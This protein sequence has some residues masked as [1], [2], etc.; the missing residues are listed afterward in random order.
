MRLG[1]RLVRGVA[2]NV[3]AAAFTNGGNLLT[4]LILA[5]ILGKE[6]L[7]EFAI[8][9]STI[10]SI[11]G[12]A[13]VA[14][15]LTANKFVAQYRSEYKE[16]AGQVLGLCAIVT[17]LTGCI[18]T[19]TLLFGASTISRYFLATPSLAS[20]ISLAA[21]AVLFSTM[22]GFQVGA[23]AGLEHYRGIASAS[24]AHAIFYVPICALLALFGGL[25]GVLIALIASAGVRWLFF[26]FVLAKELKRQGIRP[27]VK[28]LRYALGLLFTF[29]APAA[30]AGVSALTAI[31]IGNA[32][33]VRQENGL[34]E[35]GIYTAANTLRVLLLLLPALMGNVGTSIINSF[36]EIRHVGRYRTTFWATLL[37]TCASLVVGAAALLLPGKMFL[38]LFGAEFVVAAVLLPA[39]LGGAVLEG[40]SIAVYQIIQS[41]AR[42]W[43]SLFLVSLPRDCL[44]V[45]LA[46]VLVPHHGAL[47]LAV[48]YLLA[49]GVALT[50]IILISLRIGFP[51]TAKEHQVI[52]S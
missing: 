28:G 25:Q 48:A 9:Q 37:V 39:L 51:A 7:G 14:V 24:L 1:Y 16:R 12:I 47:G 52:V 21:G 46:W 50:S 22:N 23:L 32:I 4:T 41:R 30:L 29:A 33:L 44:M 45:A 26:N 18:G 5:N 15:G 49:W 35:M 10:L 6:T 8:A 31:W 38:G 27:T 36:L 11:S 17:V 34:A 3:L 19:C 20:T 42:M 13:Q 43:T 2:W 40:I